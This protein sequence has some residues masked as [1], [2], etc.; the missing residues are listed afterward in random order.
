M[1]GIGDS[2][3]KSAKDL[4]SLASFDTAQILK[5][6]DSD[7]SSSGSGSGGKIDTSGLNLTDNLKKQASDIENILNGVNLESLKQSFII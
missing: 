1:S 4:K 7:S 3:K 6:D 2:A 5:K